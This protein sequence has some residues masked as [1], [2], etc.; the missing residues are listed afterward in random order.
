MSR[1]L[2]VA[3]H[4]AVAAMLAGVGY[5]VG[6]AFQ[7]LLDASGSSVWVLTVIPPS[8]YLVSLSRRE[9]SREMPNRLI[10]GLFAMVAGAVAFLLVRERSVFVAVIAL[11]LSLAGMVMAIVAIRSARRGVDR[12]G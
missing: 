1:P 3:T 10:A 7:H 8:V 4:V 6:L 2:R 9:R 11:A 12:R 5:L